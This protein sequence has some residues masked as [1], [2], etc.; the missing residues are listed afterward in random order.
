MLSNLM[1][2]ELAHSAKENNYTFFEELLV[3]FLEHFGI[4]VVSA[5]S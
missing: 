5:R 1:A 4:V 3:P 2:F